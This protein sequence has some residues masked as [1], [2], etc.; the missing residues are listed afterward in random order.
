MSGPRR[1]TNAVEFEEALARRTPEQWAADHAKVG[2]AFVDQLSAA[3]RD[4]IGRAEY[5]LG[6]PG[7]FVEGDDMS[8]WL[9]LGL[10]DAF[11]GWANDKGQTCE[12]RPDVNFPQPVWAAAWKPGLVVCALCTDLLTTDR[13]TDKTCDGCG[14]VCAG[15]PDDPIVAVSVLAGGFCYLA[16]ACRDC[17]NEL[18]HPEPT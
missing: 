18:P 5:A 16:G 4:M 11:L 6:N 8:G 7:F 12:H 15:I 13:V 10:F 17:F 2:Q 3:A 1:I 14:H 9:R